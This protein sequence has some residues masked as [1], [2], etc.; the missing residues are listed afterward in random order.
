MSSLYRVPQW[1]LA[2]LLLCATVP[3]S[4]S[5]GSCLGD[6]NDDGEVSLLDF[7][8][9][10]NNYGTDFARADFNGNY[11]VG[12]VDFEI[13]LARF[14]NPCPCLED[15]D[16]GTG[17]GTPDGVVNADDRDY[18]Q[19][20]YDLDCRADVDGNGTVGDED[21]EIVDLSLGMTEPDADPRADVDGDNDVDAN[22]YGFVSSYLGLDCRADLNRDG[23]VDGT[24]V[25]LLLG[26]WGS[27]S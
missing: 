25:K 11:I 24:D 14:G 6:L 13:F 9:F 10:S 16:D 5:N 21:I 17:T 27:C 12:D 1:F 19:Q 18:L 3:A 23:T 15:L 4:A 26:A 7:Q 22:D 2:G 8:I 20:D